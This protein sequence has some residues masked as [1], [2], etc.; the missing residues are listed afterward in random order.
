M[1]TSI[2]TKDGVTILLQR[3]GEGIAHCV[4][5]RLASVIR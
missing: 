5:A 1:M 3:L 2:T 4:L